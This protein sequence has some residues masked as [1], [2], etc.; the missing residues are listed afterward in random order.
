M[1]RARHQVLLEA[2]DLVVDDAVLRAAFLD[3]L[4]AVLY[5]RVGAATKALADVR[6]G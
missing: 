3:P 6:E 4:K 5:R 2:H 1:L